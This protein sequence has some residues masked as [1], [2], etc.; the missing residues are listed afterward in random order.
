MDADIDTASAVPNDFAT[1]LAHHPRIRLVC[2]N[3]QTA[4]Q[5]F[6]RTVLPNLK[7]NELRTVRLPSTSPAYASMSF[8][9]KLSAWRGI[10]E[11]AIGRGE[12]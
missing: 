7:D 1:F 8:E 3:G 9:Q 2:F 11:P 6:T 10:I 4:E 5:L 12:E